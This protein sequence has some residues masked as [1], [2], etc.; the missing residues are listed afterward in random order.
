M[1]FGVRNP[2]RLG[3]GAQIPPMIHPL[4]RH[5]QQPPRHHITVDDRHALMD[6]RAFEQLAE[7]STSVPSGVYDGKMWK[8]QK[9]VWDGTPM[10]ISRGYARRK[11]LDEWILR[12]Y[13]PCDQPNACSINSRDILIT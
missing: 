1:T 8:A 11:F 13:G 5:W 10:E 12:W 7:Y 2:D 4:G 3:A 9:W 6:R